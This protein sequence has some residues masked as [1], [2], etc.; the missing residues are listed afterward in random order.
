MGG[1]PR[2]PQCFGERRRH[3]RFSMDQKYMLRPGGVSVDPAQQRSAVCVG[4]QP[5]QL[6]D[7]SLDSDFFAKK[8]DPVRPICQDTPKAAY[9]LK[10]HE[11]N[12]TFL[13]PQIV[14]QVMADP[15]GVTH[16]AGREDHL[17]NRI[18]IEKLGFLCR[19]GQAQP[20]ECQ[21]IDSLPDQ[22]GGFVIGVAAQV[23]AENLSGLPASGLST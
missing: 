5:V 9:R 13:P 8:L 15:A 3:F 22:R 12:R 23:A 6:D 7:F 14:L 11:D 18:L 20:V 16:A 17:G 10:A 19:L 21:N 1:K 2:L 4:G